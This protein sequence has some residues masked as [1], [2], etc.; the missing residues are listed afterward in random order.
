MTFRYK[1][2]LYP[3]HLKEGNAMQFIKPMAD[4]FC[5]GE[6]I[7]I[8]AGHWP[9]CADY[10]DNNKKDAHNFKGEYDYIFSS[11]CLEHLADPISVLIYWKSKIKAGGVLF[12][13]LPHPDMGYWLPQNN[14]KHLHTWY[15][16]EM[17][18]ILRDLGFKDVIY[19][20][21]DLNWSFAVVGNA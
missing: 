16:V 4:K 8:G 14:R 15:P 2:K 19:S 21:R 10:V 9:Y 11:H 5:K 3:E 18:N 20:E 12:L 1:G 13:Y 7:D 17:A 6:G